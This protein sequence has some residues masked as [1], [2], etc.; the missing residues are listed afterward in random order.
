MILKFWRYLYVS[1]GKKYPYW[2]EM[3]IESK[4]LTIVIVFQFV[5]FIILLSKHLL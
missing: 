4:L 1:Y 2:H 5:V 3:T